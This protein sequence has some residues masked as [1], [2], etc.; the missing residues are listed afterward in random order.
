MSQDLADHLE[1]FKSLGVDG[2]S[3]DPAWRVRGAHA[4]VQ[5]VQ[6]G[7]EVQGVQGVQEVQLVR[8]GGNASAAPRAPASELLA[9]LKAEIGRRDDRIAELEHE[10]WLLKRT[11]P[12]EEL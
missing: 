6:G 10:V 8:E 2:V 5:E 7:Q 4:K 9:T 11:R 3:R 1:Y 12:P